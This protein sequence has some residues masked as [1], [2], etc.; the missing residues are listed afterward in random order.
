MTTEPKGV[1]INYLP[2][3]A[4]SLAEQLMIAIIEIDSIEKIILYFGTGLNVSSHVST[5]LL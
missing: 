2:S 1:Y 3:K 5:S 4:T